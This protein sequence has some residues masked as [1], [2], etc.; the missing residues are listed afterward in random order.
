MEITK[1][2][3][4]KRTSQDTSELNFLGIIKVCVIFTGIFCIISAILLLIVSLMLF[5]A[6]DPSLFLDVAG[7]GT[8]FAASVICSFLLSKKVCQRY[9]PIGLTLGIMITLLIFLISVIFKGDSTN[10]SQI[11]LLFIPVITVIGSLLGIK[12]E[13]KQR[14]K[15]HK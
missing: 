11:W 10:S 6:E 13:K 3:R 15:R 5:N 4:T 1:R 9:I 8:L 2:K 12:K 7:K 14:H